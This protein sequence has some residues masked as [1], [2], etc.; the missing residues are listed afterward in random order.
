[1]NK[2]QT[3]GFL[4][5]IV[6]QREG[7]ENINYMTVRNIVDCLEALKLIDFDR[8]EV[9]PSPRLIQYHEWVMKME[10]ACLNLLNAS[11]GIGGRKPRDDVNITNLVKQIKNCVDEWPNVT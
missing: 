5:N 6:Q 2:N 7:S 1:M 9:V 11:C 3:I 4:S 10:Q 8:S